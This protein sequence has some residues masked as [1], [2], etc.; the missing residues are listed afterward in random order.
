MHVPSG[1]VVTIPNKMVLQNPIVNYSY[2]GRRRVELDCGISY[3]E[4][5]DF[6]EQVARKALTD[7]EKLD[8]FE[9]D[10]LYTEFG[11]S[12]INFRIR[13]WIDQLTQGEYLFI[14]S[15][16]LRAIKKAFDKNN[17]LIPFPIRTIDFAIKGGSAL[18]QQ[19]THDS[20]SNPE[21]GK[22]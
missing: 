7:I 6:V 22:D 12:S 9:V 21:N 3:G 13:F 19:L 8:D 14:K 11:D 20:V 4:D 5:L 18:S 16:A 1:Q 2:L 17:I 15:Q 10:F